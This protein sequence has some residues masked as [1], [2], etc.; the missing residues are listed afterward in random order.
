M[1]KKLNLTG[2]IFG[3][4]TVIR[5]AI[6]KTKGGEIKWV[7]KCKCGNE[8]VIA[9]SS[10]KRGN[11]KSCGCYF[12]DSVRERFTIHGWSPAI[13]CTSEYKTWGKMKDRCYNNKFRYYPY[14]GGRGI[15]VCD[16]WLG[17]HGFINFIKD[18]GPKPTPK[19]S[20]DR[21]DVNGNYEPNNCRWA[22]NYEQKRNT[23]RNIWIEYKGEKL[24]ANDWSKKLGISFWRI[25]YHFRKGRSLSEIIEMDKNKNKCLK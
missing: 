18:M 7:C 1:P 16:R 21:I 2:L 13:K 4:L 15:K 12:I 25:Q 22:T 8:S 17:E 10:L 11:S 19:H 14:Y 23:T 20:I 3:R 24:V 6:E 9:G 5:E